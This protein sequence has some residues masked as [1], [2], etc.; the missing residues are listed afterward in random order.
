MFCQQSEREF[1]LLQFFRTCRLPPGCRAREKTVSVFTVHWKR[2]SRRPSRAAPRLRS[3]YIS[4]C[5]LASE[6]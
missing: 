4:H 6:F 2:L 1:F 5:V 3:M